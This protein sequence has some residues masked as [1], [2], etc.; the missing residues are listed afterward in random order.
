M[1]EADLAGMVQGVAVAGG[2]MVS[3]PVILTINGQTL[4]NHHHHNELKSGQLV[5][6]DFGA[7]T[8]MCY[9]GDIT[10]TFP[11][12]K[13][14]TTKQKEI[15]NIVLKAETECIES[16]KP[17]VAYR[18]VHLHAAKIITNGLKDLGI[19]K[20]DTDEAVAAGAHA[21]FFPHGL[22]HMIGLDVHDMEDLG[23][24]F[25]GYDD[26]I[27]RNSQFGLKYLRLGK[28]LKKGNVLTVEPGIYFIP[29]LIDQWRS[30][31]KFT[32][33]LNYQK[34]ESYKDFSGVRIEDDVAIT[35]DGHQILGN[36][37]PKTIEEVETVREGQPG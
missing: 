27:K 34:I 14:F 12:D 1:R 37:I 28:E 21:L 4:H 5:L 19:M 31:K 2:G 23:E 30:E 3:Y 24:D 26:K 20:G 32:D 25:V 9:A 35:K 6:G 16:L 7:E 36:P 33:F 10:R 15:Y 18:D 29:E 22:G 11:V 17:G 13:K 8:S